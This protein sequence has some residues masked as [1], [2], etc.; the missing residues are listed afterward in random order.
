MLPGE[1]TDRFESAKRTIDIWKEA[2]VLKRYRSF[3]GERDMAIVN[4]IGKRNCRMHYRIFRNR[5]E[6]E[7]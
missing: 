7:C 6:H 3:A 1:G 4:K 5:N 2:A